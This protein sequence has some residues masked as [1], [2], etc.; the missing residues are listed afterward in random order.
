MAGFTGVRWTGSRGVRGRCCWARVGK[1][2]ETPRPSES[3]GCGG[4]AGTRLPS[5]KVW[6]TAGPAG[7]LRVAGPVVATGIWEKLEELLDRGIRTGGRITGVILIWAVFL[8]GGSVPPREGPE[9]DAEVVEVEEDAV[10]EVVEV[11]F[12]IR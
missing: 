1:S 7:T 9:A 5:G 12:G 3:R 2:T 10:A 11:F 8:R 6:N 4:P